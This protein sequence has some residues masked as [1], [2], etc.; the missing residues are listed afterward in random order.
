M[1][2][3]IGE[4]INGTRAPIAAAIEGRD[5]AMIKDV[6]RRQV[7]AGAAWLDV[8]AGTHPEREPEDLVWLVETVQSVVE[9]P[10]C[11]DSANPDALAAALG[12]VSQQPII[13][14][15]T[16]EPDRL[17]GIL[18]LVR[19]YNTGVI[20]LC[21][22]AG[23]IPK[24]RDA[25]LRVLRTLMETLRRSDIPD[26]EVYLDPLVMTIGTDTESSLMVLDVIRVLNTEFP[27]AHI[28]GGLSNVS[29]GLPARGVVNRAFVTLALEA[30]LDTPIIDPL[31]REM[32][33][34]ILASELLLGRD[35]H[36]LNYTRAF[37][38]GKLTGRGS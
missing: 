36:C 8:N 6:A 4:L 22:E 10:I 20:A 19:K 1:V 13:N 32:H 12:L 31:D 38:S 7:E 5:S 23:G 11:L 24:G 18:P 37:R 14:S 3:I 26:G 33:A 25:R 35:R 16:A 9:T 2:E 27:E 15:I 30:G 17:E 34:T 29:F 21:I 28:T